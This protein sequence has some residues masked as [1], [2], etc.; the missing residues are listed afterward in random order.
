MAYYLDWLGDDRLGTE[1]KPD[2]HIGTGV[3]ISGG[4]NDCGDKESGRG[5]GG[6]DK[7]SVKTD[8]QE[9]IKAEEKSS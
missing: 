1:K 9:T 8:G 2:E 3:A 4:D 6:G 5:R 7:D